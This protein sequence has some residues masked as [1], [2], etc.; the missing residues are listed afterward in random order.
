M[1]SLADPI[2]RAEILRRL[3]TLEAGRAARWGRMSTVEMVCHLADALR[4]ATGEIVTAPRTNWF[5]A[6]LLK[7]G[8]LSV[9]LQWPK[10]RIRTSPELD[11]QGA[12]TRPTT[13]AEDVAQV[14]A[15]VERVVT[16]ECGLEG[17]RHPI[18]GPLTRSEWLHWGWL[19]LD[20]HLRQF[21]A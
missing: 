19:H 10:A 2:D 13:F 14:V 17:R 9:P 11:A 6:A 3:S 18:F 1:K 20:H 15:L 7:W 4:M 12:G 8:A 21:G 5:T 16:T